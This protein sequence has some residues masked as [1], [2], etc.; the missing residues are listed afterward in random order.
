MNKYIIVLL[1]VVSIFLMVTGIWF[2]SGLAGITVAC[3]GGLCAGYVS[4]YLK[5]VRPTISCILYYATT[6][7][8]SNYVNASY[9]G[10]W[11][12]L[13]LFTTVCGQMIVSLKRDV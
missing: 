7:A 2:I 4:E 9:H 13:F 12:W 5:P 10:Y 11:F 8:G 1:V 6:I 3:L